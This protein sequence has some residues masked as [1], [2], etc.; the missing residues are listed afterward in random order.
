MFFRGVSEKY[1]IQYSSFYKRA[2]FK[3]YQDC[4]GSETTWKFKMVVSVNECKFF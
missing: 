1:F 4:K 3:G 2:D